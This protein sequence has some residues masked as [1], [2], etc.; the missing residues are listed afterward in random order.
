MH[1]PALVFLYRLL[2]E[3]IAHSCAPQVTRKGELEATPTIDYWVLAIGSAGFVIGI[4]L[5]GSRTIAT[6]GGKITKLTPS[7]SFAVQVRSA[8]RA[9]VASVGRGTR[10]RPTSARV[11]EQ[12]GAEPQMGAAIAVLSSTILG[13][14]VSTSHCLVGAVVGIG[15]AEVVMRRGS[16]QLNTKVRTE[17]H[18]TQRTQPCTADVNTPRPHVA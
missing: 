9:A 5:L 6:V 4:V 2:S 11:H 13:L 14:A 17:R 7:R 10:A 8:M 1:T 12:H 15:L 16:G 3:S 18:R